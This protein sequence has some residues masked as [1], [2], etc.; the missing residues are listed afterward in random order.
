MTKR[1]ASK[2]TLQPTNVVALAVRTA[3][4]PME[5]MTLPAE[6]ALWQTTKAI[7]T[8]DS[9]QSAVEAGLL[10]D[11]TIKEIEE[12]R[13]A[14]VGTPSKEG[15]LKYF[16]A[17]LD[18]RARLMRKPY[19]DLKNHIKDLAIVW[20]DAQRAKELKVAEKQAAK[21]AKDSPQAAADILAAATRATPA[22]AQARG[23]KLSTRVYGKLV[24]ITK[25]PAE[26]LLIDQSKVDA[27]IKAGG[28]I[29]GIERAEETKMSLGGVTE[30][31]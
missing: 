31:E 5:K 14:L 13:I 16:V 29:P 3:E 15:T 27:V 4:A 7:V 22:L 6:L 2:D 8:A 24:D 18:S 9:Y 11:R 21:V 25:V 30:V 23:A 17:K 28:T 10:C 12:K 20:V 1:T 26:Y 19:E